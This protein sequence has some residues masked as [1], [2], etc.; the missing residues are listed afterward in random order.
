METLIFAQGARVLTLKSHLPLSHPPPHLPLN[1]VPNPEVPVTFDWQQRIG[2]YV[3][4]AKHNQ[5]CAPLLACTFRIAASVSDLEA[6]MKRQ[7]SPT[8]SSSGAKAPAGTASGGASA[9]AAESQQ[10]K[11]AS[12]GSSF[13]AAGDGELASALM[14]RI[15]E[16]SSEEEDEAEEV[17]EMVPQKPITVDELSRLIFTK[18]GEW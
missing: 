11:A 13:S 14:R 10:Q 2:A 3:E 9:A 5:Q 4:T 7:T 18:Y 12:S 8:S 6:R 17:V 15:T 16:I 1:W